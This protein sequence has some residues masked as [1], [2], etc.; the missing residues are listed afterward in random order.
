[1]ESWNREYCKKVINEFL[2][3]N[4]MIDYKSD[5]RKHKR[6]TLTDENFWL[7]KSIDNLIKSNLGP[8]YYLSQWVVGLRY[9]KGD[10]FLEHS[11]GY[12]HGTRIL[13]GGIELSNENDYKGGKYTL[14]GLD[15]KNKRGYLFVHKPD[16][17]HEITEVTK[18]TR[19]SLHF[20]ISKNS[21]K[22]I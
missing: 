10:Y 18:G 13:S 3:D 17:V 12:G 7:W 4:D 16:E 21:N 9:D 2:N 1:M 5:N 15:G 20:C 11:D 6:R 8:D 22:L 14:K 19:Y